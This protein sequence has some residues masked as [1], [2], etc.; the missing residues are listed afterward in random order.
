MRTCKK[1]I[2]IIWVF[3]SVF[4]SSL[5]RV[6]A[7]IRPERVFVADSKKNKAYTRDGLIVGGDRTINDVIIKNIRRSTNP[8]FERVVIDLDANRNS[9]PAQ[10]Q[11]APYFQ[12]AVT[13]DERRIIVTFWGKP[14]LNFDSKKVIAAF[15]RSAVVKNV[16]LLP[17]L[18]ENSWTFVFE[19]KS[20]S[21]VEVFELAN[22]VRVILD[23]QRKKS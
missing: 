7:E 1:S 8:L 20:D 22:P 14:K 16:V 21:P 17:R 18:E 4:T 15:K 13:P 11:R 19:L 12:L 5:T 9:E 6:E 3:A 23:I 10:I 2:W